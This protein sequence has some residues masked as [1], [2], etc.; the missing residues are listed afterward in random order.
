M[1]AARQHVLL[2][3][4]AGIGKSA[5]GA[6]IVARLG[7]RFAGGAYWIACDHLAG[8]DALPDLW[9]AIALALFLE[10]VAAETDPARAL[11]GLMNL[12][13]QRPPMLLALDNL[14]PHLDVSAIVETLAASGHTLLLTTPSHTAQDDQMQ[15]IE[16]EPL[17]AVSARSLFTRCL[18][19]FDDVTTVGDHDAIITDCGGSPLALRLTAA[20][21]GHGGLARP[22]SVVQHPEGGA[23]ERAFDAVWATLSNPE[24]ILSSAVATLLGGASFP[25]TGAI[26]LGDEMTTAALE[27]AA[28]LAPIAPERL[29]MHPAVR[30]LA[31]SHWDRIASPR[32]ETLTDAALDFW[33]AFAAQHPGY[34][35]TEAIETDMAGLLTALD[36]ALE[37]D[38]DAQAVALAQTIDYSL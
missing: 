31:A 17:R 10:G 6:E 12:L 38:R 22:Q 16:L 11:S 7:P 8:A 18:L 29:L 9:T 21:I 30:R 25:R 14:A 13:R 33:L 27:R 32:Q 24:R 19:R 28:L 15:T 5:L 37:H 1:L 3:G 2:T 4:P 35:A 36:W 26:A 23:V 20:A 34:T